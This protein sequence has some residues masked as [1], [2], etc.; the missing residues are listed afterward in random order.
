VDVAGSIVHQLDTTH[1]YVLRRKMGMMFQQSG[2]F[3]D[4]SVFENIAFPSAST[5][6]ARVDDPRLVLMK[7]QAVGLRGA[8]RLRPANFQA[9]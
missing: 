2:L 1:L 9:A 3:T 8:W 7:L 6:P 5:R 4:L